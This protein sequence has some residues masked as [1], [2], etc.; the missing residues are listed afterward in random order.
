M[1]VDTEVVVIAEMSVDVSVMADVSVEVAD[2]VRVDV[3]A[4]VRVEVAVETEVIGHVTEEVTVETLINV[5]VE[6]VVNILVTVTGSIGKH[7]VSDLGGQTKSSGNLLTPL[8]SILS[9]CIGA[10]TVQVPSCPVAPGNLEQGAVRV[11]AVGIGQTK[12]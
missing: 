8:G 6:V 4:E 12:D 2:D 9:K 3:V 5:S 10:N 1:T 11:R 7:P